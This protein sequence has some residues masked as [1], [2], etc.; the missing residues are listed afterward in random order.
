MATNL[1]HYELMVIFTPILS[2]EEFKSAQKSLSHSI[3]EHGGKII[4]ENPWGLRSLAYPIQKKT[5]GLYHVL[6]F[7]APGES[8]E[9]LEI[10]MNRDEGVMRHMVT[11]LDKHAVAYNERKRKP[12]EKKT[13]PQEEPTDDA[14]Q[15][16]L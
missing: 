7:Q 16:E 13:A 11:H 9:K 2:E 3:K 10:Q 15:P 8:I 4:H 1:Q 12:S 5:T 14:N 6:E